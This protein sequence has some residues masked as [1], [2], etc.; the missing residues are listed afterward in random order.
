MKSLNGIILLATLILSHSS[1]TNGPAPP[2]ELKAGLARIVITPDKPLWMAG[3]AARTKPAE[4][5][6]QDLYAKALAI[7]DGTGNRL[8]IVTSDILGFPRKTADKITT[9]AGRRYGLGREAILLN[10]SHTHSGPVLR[11]SLAG[12]YSLEK[13]QIDAIDEY[14]GWME[15]RIVEL[16]GKAIAD[17]APARVSYGVGEAPFAMNRRKITPDG[18]VNSPNPGGVVDRSVPVLKVESPDGRLRG[19]LFGYACHN[20]TLTGEFTQWSGDYA[21]FAQ[22]EIER[23]HAGA[24]ALFMMGCGADVNPYPR[25]KLELAPQ[26]GK[27]LADAVDAVLKG[28]MSSVGGPVQTAF[29]TVALPFAPPPTREM[30]TAQLKHPNVFHQRHASRMLD[31]LEKDGRLISEYPFPVQVVR[32]GA[33]FTLIALAGETATEYALRL[34]RE[35]KGR[36]W[37]AGYSNDVFAYVASARMFPEGGY[38]VVESMIYY[39]Q[40]GPFLPVIEEKII[41]KTKAL[42]SAA[43][44]GAAVKPR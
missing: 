29:D 12:A 7:E 31:R 17:L 41:E 10:S 40:P 22:Q 21:G 36:V 39:D 24:T 2:A 11:D 19:L 18:V 5:K 16:I 23:R 32:I 6:L 14:T 38:E 20:T 13:A 42:W 9:E 4:G 8:V 37:V 3:Y 44:A 26:H 28:R 35:I 27:A 30:L 25:S 1:S 15:E 34:K 43:P 33:D